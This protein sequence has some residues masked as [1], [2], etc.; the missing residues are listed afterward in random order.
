MATAYVGGG[1]ASNDV[2]GTTLDI[3]YTVTSGTCLLVWCKHE[4]A[5]GSISVAKSDGTNT[6]TMDTQIHETTFNDCHGVMGVLLTHSMSGSTTFRMTTG[7][8]PYRRFF[9]MEFSY[10][11]TASA[12]GSNQAQSD[13]GGSD[14]TVNSG[15]ITTTGTD[16]IVVGGYGEYSAATTSSEQINSVA[17]DGKLTVASYPTMWRRL[18][19]STFTGAAT[20]TAT[21]ASHHVEAVKAVK[22]TAA[23]GGGRVFRLTMLGVG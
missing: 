8:V 23:G 15:N 3:T 11:G 19:T 12:D 20:A 13:G 9:L 22:I 10:S 2:A 1:T 5:A 6:F 7:S 21:G 14:T 17:A 18:V 4:G 16:E